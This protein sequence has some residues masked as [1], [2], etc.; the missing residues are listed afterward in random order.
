MR[1]IVGAVYDDRV[2]CNTELVDLV[3]N[4]ADIL[5][6]I[7]HRIM[8]GR[9]PHSGLVQALLFGVGLQMHMGKVDPGKER[10][11]GLD[12]AFHE[13]LG[14]LGDLI[15]EVG[16]LIL[17]PHYITLDNL[18]ADLAETRIDRWVVLIAGH[19]IDD[20]TGSLLLEEVPFGIVI[21]LNVL[22]GV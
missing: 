2:V 14:T 4:L 13:V 9:L 3:E 12:L 21:A 6:V 8:V 17:L 15:V 19:R 22:H 18:L 10:F 7:D 20:P 1:A 11:V 5:V 16:N